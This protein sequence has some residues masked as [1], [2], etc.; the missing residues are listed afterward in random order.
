MKKNQQVGL[1][2]LRNKINQNKNNKIK[3]HYDYSEEE[4]KSA[5][6]K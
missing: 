5:S 1:Y 6:T 2:D 4:E 3:N